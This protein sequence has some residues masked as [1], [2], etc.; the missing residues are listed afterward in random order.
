LL[1]DRRRIKYWQKWIY[2]L[3]AVLM[4]A[5]L[6]YIPIGTQGCSGSSP[7]TNQAAKDRIATL[8]TQLQAS[9]GVAATML[10]L[11]EAY[12]LAA[13]QQTSGSSQQQADLTNAA[14]YYQQY[15]DATKDQKTATAVRQRIDTMQTLASV[16][17]NLSDFAKAVTIYGQLTAVQPDN[18]EFFLQLGSFAVNASQKKVALLAFTRYLQLAPNSPEAKTI[19]EYIQKNSTSATPTA[20]ASSTPKASASPKASPSASTTPTTSPSP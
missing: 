7:S 1:L 11:A 20:S 17:S 12:Q 10:A 8:K 14:A 19:K 2:G 15:L 6:V 18:A 5:F 13:G 16:Y 9:P 4:V 3:M